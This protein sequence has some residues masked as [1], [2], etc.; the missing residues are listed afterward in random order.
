LFRIAVGIT[1]YKLHAFASVHRLRIET[2]LAAPRSTQNEFGNFHVIIY[3][4]YIKAINLLIKINNLYMYSLN[5][6]QGNDIGA[7]Y[8]IG[9]YWVV[10][11][12]RADF[13]GKL[14]R[15]RFKF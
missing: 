10:R 12:V 2:T 6:N 14:K 9:N 7:K 8:I 4:I 5:L 1:W 3:K 13:E 11:K 15:R